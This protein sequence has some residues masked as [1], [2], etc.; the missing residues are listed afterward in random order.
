MKKPRKERQK[1]NKEETKTLQEKKREREKES[2]RS[3]ACEK[4]DKQREWHALKDTG[5][6]AEREIKIIS[7][8]MKKD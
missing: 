4:M 3:R 1:K 2:K 7:I 5:T 8:E 6:R